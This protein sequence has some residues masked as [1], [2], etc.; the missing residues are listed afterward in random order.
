MAGNERLE[1]IR[2]RLMTSGSVNVEE[3]KDIY[4]VSLETI[5]R[6]LAKLVDEGT[7]IRT[8]GGAVINKEAHTSKIDFAVRAETHLREKQKIAAM[9]VD[10]V[11]PFSHIGCDAST[12]ALEV[13]RLVRD[14]EDIVILTN[15]V[16]ALLEMMDSKC[17]LRSTGGIVDPKAGYMMGRAAADVIRNFN[18]DISFLSCKGIDQSGNVFDTYESETELK[19]IFMQKS[20]QKILLAGHSKIGR[21]GFTSWAKVWDFDLFI[22]DEMPPEN[23]LRELRERDVSFIYKKRQ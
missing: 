15:S 17:E 5:R 19:Q 22:T 6:D 16:Q 11:K 14:R 9:A 8:Y 12:T 2:M 21:I 10:F 13:L 7:A 4:R 20:R 3:L 23:L 1:S 18:L